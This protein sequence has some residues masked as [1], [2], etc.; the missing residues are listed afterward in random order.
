MATTDQ[1][2]LAEPL[3]DR[4]RDI[5]FEEYSNEDLYSIFYDNME[6]KADIKQSVQED[7]VST[8]RGNPRDALVKAEDLKTFVSLDS[9]GDNK[10]C[11]AGLL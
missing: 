10:I 7:I 3:R 6:N 4:L 1:Q 9:K 2:K 8:F 5:A 11:M